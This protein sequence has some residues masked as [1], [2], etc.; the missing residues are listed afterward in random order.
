[1]QELLYIP[2]HT[3]PIEIKSKIIYNKGNTEDKENYIY[4][5]SNF[6][7]SFTKKA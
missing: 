4:E 5:K 7:I 2:Y 3:T 1:M 6:S